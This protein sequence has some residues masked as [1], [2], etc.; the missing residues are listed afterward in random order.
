MVNP[1]HSCIYLSIYLLYTYSLSADIVEC[2]PTV[3]DCGIVLY[4]NLP[5]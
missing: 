3:E 5:L 4:V 1:L 2:R